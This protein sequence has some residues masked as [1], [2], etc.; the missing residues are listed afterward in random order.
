MVS[1]EAQATVSEGRKLVG[2][3]QATLPGDAR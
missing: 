2:R 1:E 3:V